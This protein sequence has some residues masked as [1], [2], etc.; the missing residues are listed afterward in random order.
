MMKRIKKLVHNIKDEIESAECYTE[1]FLK[2][3]V[4]SNTKTAARMKEMA[5]Q[6]L[7][8]A[9]TLHTIAASEIERLSHVITPPPEMMEKWEKHHADYIERV[10]KVKEILSA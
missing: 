7:E 4:D 10:A 1:E 9:D 8:H 5:L 6:E 2:A 3:L